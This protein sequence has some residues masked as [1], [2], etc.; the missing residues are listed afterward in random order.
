M[1][2]Q[3]EQ[4]C[5]NLSAAPAGE[6]G[7]NWFLDAIWVDWSTAVAPGDQD[8]TMGAPYSTLTAAVAGAVAKQDALPVG[9]LPGERGGT[10]Q[11][12]VV[13]GGIYDEDLLLTRGDTFY[14]FLTMGPVTLGNGQGA[15]F[16]STNS[17]DLVWVN[18]QTSEDA[19]T[20]GLPGNRRPQ[21]VIAPMYDAGPMSSTHTSVAS[22]MTIS[23]DFVLQNPDGGAGGTTAEIHLSHVK[24]VG[25][26]TRDNGVDPDFGIRNCYLIRCFF[27]QAFNIERQGGNGGGNLVEVIDTEFDGLITVDSYSRMVECEIGGGMTTVAG[28]S[29]FLPPGG[30][31]NTTFFGTYTGP[32]ASL[33]LDAATNYFFKTN[34]AALAGGATKVILGDLVP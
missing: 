4:K 27:D 30:M 22:G 20:G 10:R 18:S 9:I 8:G 19:D 29:N 28:F 6:G 2:L 25:D 5:I 13:A 15:N 1:A 7:G 23:G 3:Y 34:G 21:L 32:A 31:Y 16:T 11:V 33:L 24:V 26:L 12:F 14:I 17:R